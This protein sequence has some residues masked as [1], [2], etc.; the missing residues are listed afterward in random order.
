MAISRRGQTLAV[1]VKVAGMD[2]W[3]DKEIAPTLNPN[4]EAKI[5]PFWVHQKR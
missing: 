4:M 3:K 5:V 1:A 2:P